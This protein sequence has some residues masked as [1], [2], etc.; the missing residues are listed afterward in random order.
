M[1]KKKQELKT[2][3]GEGEQM[4]GINGK[5]IEWKVEQEQV[6]KEKENLGIVKEE[7]RRKEKEDKKSEE[8]Q[9]RE[10]ERGSAGR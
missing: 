9:K 6:K 5:E 10:R 3:G 1:Y 4:E 2:R 8:E 7:R